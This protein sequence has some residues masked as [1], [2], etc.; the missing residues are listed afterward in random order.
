MFSPQFSD[1]GEIIGYFWDY[2][3][4]NALAAA[5]KTQQMSPQ[6]CDINPNPN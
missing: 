1:Q 4:G 2:G 5:I 6:T 3:K